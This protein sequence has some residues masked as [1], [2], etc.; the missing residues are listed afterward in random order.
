[1]AEIIEEMAVRLVSLEK[2]VMDM[3]EQTRFPKNALADYP[4]ASG[5]LN[6]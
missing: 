6:A 1:M 4:E 2:A 3:D 5:K